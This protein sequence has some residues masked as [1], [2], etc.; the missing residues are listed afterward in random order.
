MTPPDPTPPAP[1]ASRPRPR[2]RGVFFWL[3]VWFGASSFFIGLA[4]LEPGHERTP[5]IGRNAVIAPQPTVEVPIGRPAVWAILR[6]AVSRPSSR[7]ARTWTS[8]GTLERGGPQVQVVVDGQTEVL[9]V[10][11]RVPVQGGPEV[12][13]GGSLDEL[14]ITEAQCPAGTWTDYELEQRALRPGDR[15]YLTR[16]ARRTI[17]LGDQAQHLEDVS[18]HNERSGKPAFF[19]MFVGVLCGVAAWR[20]RRRRAA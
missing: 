5:Q 11:W 16:D 12:A 20:L 7:G 1:G 10:S 18:H 8:C 17:I 13:R 14:K 19:A 6:T 15:V 3:A 4:M 2:S 9:D